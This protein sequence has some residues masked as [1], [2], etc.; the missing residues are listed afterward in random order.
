M[1]KAP[2]LVHLS[3]SHVV[4]M[5]LMRH[6]LLLGLS[7]GG[8]VREVAQ[9]TVTQIWLSYLTLGFTLIVA[10]FALS[11]VVEVKPRGRT[12]FACWLSFRAGIDAPD[13]QSVK[14]ILERY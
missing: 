1:G 11:Q 13:V 9:S 2:L 7:A 8:N 6:P 14:S 12:V 4:G 5:A 3:T 10:S